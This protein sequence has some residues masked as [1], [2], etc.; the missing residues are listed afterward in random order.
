MSDEPYRPAERLV[1]WLTI[2][3]VAYAVF[4]LMAAWFGWQ[5]MREVEAELAELQAEREQDDE[6]IVDGEPTQSFVHAYILPGELT[7]AFLGQFGAGIALIV[8]FC[9]WIPRANRNAR[10]LGATGMVFSPRSCVIWYLIPILNLFVPYLAMK[11]I[12]LASDPSGAWQRRKA[13]LLLPLWWGLFLLSIL[14]SFA[15]YGWQP[16]DN[17]CTPSD[18]WRCRTP[19]TLRSPSWLCC[20]CGRSTPGRNTVVPPPPSTDRAAPTPPP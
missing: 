8:L 7:L 3:L 10:A 20:W 1:K 18:S 13:S 9:L 17:F 15:A 16:H 19:S 14:A 11:E 5:A 6:L 2:L 12:W 4:C